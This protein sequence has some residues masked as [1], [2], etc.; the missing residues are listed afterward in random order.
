MRKQ[1]KQVREEI[2]DDEGN[3]LRNPA[4]EEEEDEGNEDDVDGKSA[5]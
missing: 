5:T 3:D 2:F 4:V 1:L